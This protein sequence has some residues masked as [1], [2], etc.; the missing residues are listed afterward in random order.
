MGEFL[1]TV[2]DSWLMGVFLGLVGLAVGSFLNVC[3]HRLPAG[4][5]LVWPG[6]HCPACRAPIRPWDNIPVLSYFFLRGRCRH[7]GSRFSPRY[8]LVEAATGLIFFGYWL[9]YFRLGVRPGAAHPGVYGV[10]LVLLG[11]LLVSGAIDLERKEIYTGVTNLALGVGVAGSFLWP[12]V[13]RIGAYDRVLAPIAGWAHA[14]AAILSLVGAGV[15][16]GIVYLTRILATQAFKKEAMG[17]GD[18][19]LMAAVGA[20]LGWN[21]AI[22]IFFAA[23]F[24]ALPYGLVQVAR[25][26]GEAEEREEEALKRPSLPLGGLLGTAG[27]LGMLVWAGLEARTDGWATGPRVLLALGMLALGYGLSRAVRE[28]DEEEAEGAEP[29]PRAPESHEVPYGPFLGAAAAVVM[30]A[31]DAIVGYL[32][33]RMGF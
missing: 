7:C 30:L 16:G 1:A 5:S 20:V 17:I 18:V 6:S 27:G 25:Q 2:A 10:H 13:Q 19:Y 14:D 8:A 28:E 22:L 33:V 11:A 21:A 24:L 3:I 26:R 23:P 12:Q 29:L 15:G 9:A 32:G 4:K 31:Q